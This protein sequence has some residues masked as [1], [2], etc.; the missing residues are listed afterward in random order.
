MNSELAQPFI[1]SFLTIFP[2][3][4]FEDVHKVKI[5]EIGKNIESPGVNVIIGMVGD[6][7]G[8][9]IYGMCEDCAKTIA[10]TMMMGME[11]TEFDAMA[12]SAVSELCNMLTATASTEFTSME[13]KTDISTPT[14]MYGNFTASASYEH[15]VR[16]EMQV[17]D[18]PFYIYFSLEKNS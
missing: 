8:N 4:G 12:Q 13:I 11:V 7:K 6:L 3:I 2:Q 18:F 9:V 14:L 17:L 10:S 5:D 15:V 16:L 1:N